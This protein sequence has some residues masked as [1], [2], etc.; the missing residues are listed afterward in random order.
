[1]GACLFRLCMIATLATQCA[2]LR[3]EAGADG[4]PLA[5]VRGE[6]K[7]AERAAPAPPVRAYAIDGLRFYYAGRQF[8]VDGLE[9]AQPGSELAKQRLQLML[10][11]GELSVAPVGDVEGELVP[12]RVFVDGMGLPTAEH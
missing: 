6:P 11:A 8:V 4:L 12:A 7:P 10:D 3:A 1:M 5:P 2:L 9:V